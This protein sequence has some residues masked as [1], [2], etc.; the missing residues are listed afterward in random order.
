MKKI[1]WKLCLVADADF[2][3]GADL[4]DRVWRSVQAGATLVQL[5]AKN[6]PAREF[7]DL[8]L[9]IATK[10]SKVKLPLLINDRLDIALAGQASGVH[11][12]QDD[13]PLV[14]ARTLLGHGRLIGIS[15]ATVEE[16]HR[17][18]TGGADYIGVGPVFATATKDCGRP[19]IGLEGLRRIREAVKIPLLAIG[20]ID[21][22]NA[23]D[24]VK[25]GADG[26]AVVSALMNA[27]DIGLATAELLKVLS[28]AAPPRDG[29][30]A[31][32]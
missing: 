11:L 5:R 25:A 20:G 12:G 15:A 1:D 18:W 2:A 9:A 19:P 6:L 7:L 27:P 4:L 31:R 3:R 13:I 30:S 26:I 23:G 32:S 28:A 17:A 21:A 8:S 29:S 14:Y 22:H 24:V 10:L 16:A